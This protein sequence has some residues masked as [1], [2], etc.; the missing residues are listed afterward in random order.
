[1]NA[2]SLS[3]LPLVCSSRPARNSAEPEALCQSRALGVAQLA[4]VDTA[5]SPF[6]A[7]GL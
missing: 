6:G 5:F 2:C 3:G 1:V 7:P 4:S